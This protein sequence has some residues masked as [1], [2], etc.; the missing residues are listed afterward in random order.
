MQAKSAE[1][2]FLLSLLFAG[3]SENGKLDIT[4]SN[5]LNEQQ[6]QGL[7]FCYLQRL[8]PQDRKSV[9]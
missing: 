9:V 1:Y 6:N 2:S 7:I 5:S 8:Q 4:V 3:E